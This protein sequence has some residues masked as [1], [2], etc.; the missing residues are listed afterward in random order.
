M[1]TQP[2]KKRNYGKGTRMCRLCG[3]HKGIIRR[4]K[5]LICRRCIREVGNEIGFKNTGA[6]G[7]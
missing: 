3:T 5:L 7:G 2:K 1:S 6:R 4:A